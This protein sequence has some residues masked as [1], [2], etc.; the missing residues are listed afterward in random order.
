MTNVLVSGL[1]HLNIKAI[2]CHAAEIRVF[3]FHSYFLAMFKRQKLELLSSCWLVSCYR[4]YIH[5]ENRFNLSQG[6]SEAPGKT[7]L[8]I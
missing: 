6:S 7:K 8:T 4:D 3:P 1:V 5:I 2:H